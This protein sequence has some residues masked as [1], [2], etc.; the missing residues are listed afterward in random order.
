MTRVTRL[1]ILASSGVFFAGVSAVWVEPEPSVLPRGVSEASLGEPTAV[2][3]EGISV[4]RD[5]GPDGKPV[6]TFL[7]GWDRVREVTGPMRDEAAKFAEVADK[8]WRARVRLERGDWVAAEPLFE[9]LFAEYRPRTGPTALTVAGGLLRCRLMRGAQTAA[10]EPWISWT[11]AQTVAGFGDAL[12]ESVGAQVAKLVDPGT[13]L[14]PGLPPMWLS[15]AAVQALARTETPAPDPNSKPS[16]QEVRAASL[17]TL[18]VLAAKADSG[19]AGSLP[20][21]GG[22]TADPGVRLIFDIVKSRLGDETQRRDARRSL[23]ERITGS[24]QPWIE[25][26]CRVAVGRSLLLEAGDEDRRLGL[27]SLAYV[28]SR[29]TPSDAYLIGLSLAEMALA[30]SKDGNEAAA[31]VLA[32]EVA[33]R[34]P[35]HPALESPLM[36]KWMLARAARPAKPAPPTTPTAAP[37]AAPPTVPEA[38]PTP[39]K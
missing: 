14:V 12:P 17:L 32:N 29:S 10:V 9:E 13:G 37:P 35:D 15:T 26:W 36:A 22:V 19:S 8:A 18:Y 27:A 2:A 33:D 24:A 5:R 30:L 4:V 25:V 23:Q 31:S 28:A 3:A 1:A 21:R 39:P 6:A 38:Q 16:P 7:I 20:E 34:F 11:R